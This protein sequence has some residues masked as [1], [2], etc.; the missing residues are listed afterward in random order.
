MSLNQ[1]CTVYT[2]RLN[3]VFVLFGWTNIAGYER[4]FTLAS[5]HLASRNTTGLKSTPGMVVVPCRPVRTEGQ[6]GG[7]SQPVSTRG[8]GAGYAHHITKGHFNSEWIYEVIVSPKM[9]T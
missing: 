3:S 2:Y 4:I 1:E 5:V 8:M 6:G 7:G 9:Q